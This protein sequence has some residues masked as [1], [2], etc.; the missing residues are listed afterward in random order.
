MDQIKTIG[1]L[2]YPSCSEQDTITPLEIFR[3]AA[4]VLGQSWPRSR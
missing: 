1:I 3:G 4:M 2:A